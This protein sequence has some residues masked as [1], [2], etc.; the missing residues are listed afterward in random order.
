MQLIG[1]YTGV[2]AVAF[3][4]PVSNLVQTALGFIWELP[5]LKSQV[6]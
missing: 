6:I 4:S 5:A 3:T 2:S 1:G